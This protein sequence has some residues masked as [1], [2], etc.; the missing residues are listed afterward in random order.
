MI[1]ICI[2]L[3]IYYLDFFEFYAYFKFQRYAISVT[4]NSY[5][6]KRRLLFRKKKSLSFI[7]IID[8]YKK[9]NVAQIVGSIQ[10]ND[11]ISEFMRAYFIL[12]NNCK[13]NSSITAKK[14]KIDGKS[15]VINAVM[16]ILDFK[17]IWFINKDQI[18]P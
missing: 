7:E 11:I 1:T 10:Y 14:I 13:I 3:L 2:R 6:R 18:I 12:N 17:I 8:P 5:K 9:C 15:F 4:N 16:N